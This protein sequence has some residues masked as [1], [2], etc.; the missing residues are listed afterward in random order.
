MINA[1]H[2]FSKSSFTQSSNNLIYKEN[3]R[4]LQKSLSYSAIK[5]TKQIKIKQTEKAKSI[6]EGYSRL[7]FFKNINN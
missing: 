6:T 7:C 5:K 3:N 1:F 2:H 4:Q